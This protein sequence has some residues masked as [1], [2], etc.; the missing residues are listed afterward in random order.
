M[1][2]TLELLF[3]KRE[4]MNGISSRVAGPL[5]GPHAISVNIS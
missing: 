4:Q 2:L 3:A 5:M 1:T